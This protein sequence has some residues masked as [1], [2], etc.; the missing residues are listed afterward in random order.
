MQL[1]EAIRIL[2]EHEADLKKMGVKNLYMFGSTVRGEA[3]SDSD[4]DLFYDHD[5]DAIGLR[6]FFRIKDTA[7][8]ILG[9]EVD[10]MTRDS[11]NRHVRPY[12]EQEAV[13]VF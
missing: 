6:E 11:I 2:R 10:I 4:V 5:P 13:L 12:A 8:E 1:V 7:A 9:C 3:T